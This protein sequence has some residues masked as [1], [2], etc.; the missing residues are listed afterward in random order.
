[1][2]DALEDICAVRLLRLCTSSMSSQ[3]LCVCKVHVH[4]RWY[5]PAAMRM[6]D[7]PIERHC[8]LAQAEDD[9]PVVVAWTNVAGQLSETTWTSNTATEEQLCADRGGCLFVASADTPIHDVAERIRSMLIAW[10]RAV[11]F[12][13]LHYGGLSA[14]MSFASTRRGGA[15][16]DYTV[17]DLLSHVRTQGTRHI[18]YAQLESSAR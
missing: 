14:S 3:N 1:M 10:P 8:L 17:L 9:L 5:D 12:P 2:I 11:N 13:V 15:N 16:V 4:A 7:L 6:G 18:L